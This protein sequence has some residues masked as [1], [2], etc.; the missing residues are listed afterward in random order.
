VLVVAGQ[1]GRLAAQVPLKSLADMGG[2][3]HAPWRAAD[4]AARGPHQLSRA[5]ALIR[6][7]VCRRGGGAA[8]GD[9]GRALTLARDDSGGEAP[10]RLG[11]ASGTGP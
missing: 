11:L 1:E 7:R 8:R 10:W 4:G 6:G 2:G 5:R 3:A 9:G